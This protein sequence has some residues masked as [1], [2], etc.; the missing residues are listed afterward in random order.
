S[1]LAIVLL[2]AALQLAGLGRQDLPAQDGLK[3]LQAARRFQRE[4]WADVIRGTDRH[5]LYPALIALVEPA[6]SAVTRPGP[7]AWCLSARL[8]S[9]LAALM[10]LGPLFG[11]T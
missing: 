7:E 4:P 2:A 6:A 10:L 3:F 11:L 1:L 9:I 8:V 5:P